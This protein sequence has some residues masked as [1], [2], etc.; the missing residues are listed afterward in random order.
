[1]ELPPQNALSCIVEVVESAS[2]PISRW[3]CVKMSIKGKM[4]FLQTVGIACG[5]LVA[6]YLVYDATTRVMSVLSKVK[7]ARAAV[8]CQD[9][10]HSDREALLLEEGAVVGPQRRG[11]FVPTI[12]EEVV[13]RLGGRPSSIAQVRAAKILAARL[14]K[15]ANHRTLHIA[16]D[17]PRV[18]ML[19]MK[20]TDEERN[21]QLAMTH[22]MISGLPDK[23]NY[24]VKWINGG[25]SSLQ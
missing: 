17:L 18:M 2:V 7:M 11:V 13:L 5:S 12:A 9:K 15:E 21:L 19:V 14:M 3:D 20:P 1:M 4:P 8:R 16:R 22:G 25:G 23:L 24:F 10:L 6:V